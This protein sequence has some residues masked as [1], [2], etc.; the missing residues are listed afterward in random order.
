MPGNLYIY[1]ILK[2]YFKSTLADNDKK[3]STKKDCQTRVLYNANEIYSFIDND[4]KSMVLD[5]PEPAEVICTFDVCNIPKSASAISKSDGKKIRS[6]PHVKIGFNPRN[7]TMN[8]YLSIYFFISKYNH[9]SFDFYDNNTFKDRNIVVVK[10]K[11]AL[12]C[13]LDQRGAIAMLTIITDPTIVDIV[14][15]RINSLFKIQHL[16]VTSMTSAELVSS[17]YRSNFYAF[18]DYH[19]FLARGFEYLLPPEIIDN[20][21]EAAY[22]QGY[23]S[24]TE[25]MLRTL[26]I[27]WEDLFNKEHLEFFMTKSDLIR[28]VEDGEFYFTDIVYRMSI[29]ERKKHIEHILEL[30][31]KNDHISFY[32]LDDEDIPYS[33]QNVKF[34]IYNNHNKLFLKNT[35]RFYSSYGPQFYSILSDSI[36]NGISNSFEKLKELDLCSHYSA[37]SIKPFMDQYGAMVYR[38]LSLSAI[39]SKKRE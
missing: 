16:L 31:E 27:T 33:H 37:K 9:V 35:V 34:S 2:D 17:G 20:I 13:S 19:I 4:L 5:S 12:M 10:S 21:V 38:M 30:C 36:I 29:E 32:I 3:S 25:K 8:D 28:Y 23:D 26:M 39:T 7:T 6:T 1:T 18:N 14:Y 11:V 24:T 22:S 15:N